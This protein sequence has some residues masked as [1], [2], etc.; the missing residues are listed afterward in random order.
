MPFVQ[1]VIAD[2]CD[3]IDQFRVDFGYMRATIGKHLIQMLHGRVAV[4]Q[5]FL[6]KFD[7]VGRKT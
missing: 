6:E 4:R 5:D 2:V 3:D 1:L 7:D